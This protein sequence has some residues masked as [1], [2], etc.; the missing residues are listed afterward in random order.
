[1]VGGVNPNKKSNSAQG[2]APRGTADGILT[3]PTNVRDNYGNGLCGCVGVRN[4]QYR[5]FI[6][7]IPQNSRG[8]AVVIRNPFDGL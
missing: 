8:K 4:D 1:M 2:Y 7:N 6:N 5:Q 3:H